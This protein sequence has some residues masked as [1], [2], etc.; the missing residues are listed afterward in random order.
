MSV[1]DGAWTALK[2]LAPADTIDSACAPFISPDGTRLFFLST[3]PIPGSTTPKKENIWVAERV[4]D[5]WGEP[6]PLPP[7][8]NNL[9]IH[10]SFSTASNGDLYFAAGEGGINDLYVSRLVDGEYAI[11]Q[12]LDAPVNTPD[13]YEL[14]PVIAPDGSWLLF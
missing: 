13:Q 14:T 5:S 9:R 8:V 10:W 2:R 1:V 6:R 4:S 7:V 3:A 12:K 11:P